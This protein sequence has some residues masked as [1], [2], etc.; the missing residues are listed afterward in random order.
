MF[1]IILHLK[2]SFH[3]DIFPLLG[4]CSQISLSIVRQTSC[5]TLLG[6]WKDL[7]YIPC[8]PWCVTCWQTCC[9]LGWQAVTGPQCSSGTFSHISL[10][11][12][13]SCVWQLCL[14]ET[15]QLWEGTLSHTSLVSGLQLSQT[16]LDTCSGIPRDNQGREQKHITRI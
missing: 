6:T 13:F 7:S 4:V 8:P 15:V 9:E 1:V 14:G 11:W 12:V 2:K 10:G 3:F 16:C 5:G